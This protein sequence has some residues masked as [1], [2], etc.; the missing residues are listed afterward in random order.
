[1]GIKVSNG[2]LLDW[3]IGQCLS[4]LSFAIEKLERFPSCN[5]SIVEQLGV[6]LLRKSERDAISV[7]VVNQAGLDIKCGVPVFRVGKYH[8]RSSSQI[9][10]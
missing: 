2:N 5:D 8:D 7:A 3:G 6:D 10:Q 9:R 4:F 1:M